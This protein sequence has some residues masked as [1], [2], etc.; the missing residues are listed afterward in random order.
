MR[1]VTGKTRNQVF[2][3]NDPLGKTEMPK[4]SGKK[5]PEMPK[6][7]KLFLGKTDSR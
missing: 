5:K 1:Y 2:T 6:M 3:V 7:K 4:I